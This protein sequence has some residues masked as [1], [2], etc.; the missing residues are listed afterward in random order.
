MLVLSDRAQT[1]GNVFW[2]TDHGIVGSVAPFNVLFKASGGNFN[3]GINLVTG[4]GNDTVIVQSQFPGAPTA[5]YSNGG[6]DAFHVG[7]SANH[8]YQHLT[9]DGGFGSDTLF[10]YDQSGGAVMHNRVFAA[11]QGQVEVSY[12]LG[13]DSVAAYQSME[14]QYTSVDA[15]SSYVQALYNT[16]LGE[17]ATP[18]DLAF[19][20]GVLSGSGRDAVVQGI[21]ASAPARLRVAEGWLQQ[22]LGYTPA[23][24]TAQFWADQLLTH[25]HEEALAE[26]LATPDYYAH[27][28]GTD[29]AFAAQLYRDLLDHDPSAAQM[30]AAL[31]SVLPQAGR[32][33]LAWLIM[34]SDEYRRVTMGPRFATLGRAPSQAELAYWA[35]TGKTQQQIDASFYG[36][37]EFYFLGG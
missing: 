10:V 13:Q 24:A 2:V 17:V 25:G 12:L 11:G 1:A 8:P 37:D 34:T 30:Q 16:A 28:G 4:G 3:R 23:L 5:I 27:A 14:F 26:F 9:L 31:N 20:L 19:W 33:G 22:Y 29:A 36:S 32:A 21:E 18:S 6:D 7:V 15:A 35:S